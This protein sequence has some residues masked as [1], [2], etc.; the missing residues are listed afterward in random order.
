MPKRPRPSPET[1]VAGIVVM[2]IAGFGA[3]ILLM[4]V[5]KFFLNA[6][7]GLING[8]AAATFMA[9]LLIDALF[10]WLLLS[11][12]RDQRKS[13]DLVELKTELNRELGAAQTHSLREPAMSVTDHTTRTLEPVAGRRD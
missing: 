7:N 5:M 12:K 6:D 2:T 9:F 10:A 3:V 4:A 8:F 11:S 13:S 1:L